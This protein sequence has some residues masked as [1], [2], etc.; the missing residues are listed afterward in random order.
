MHRCG[1]IRM[2]GAGRRSRGLR[3]ALDHEQIEAIYWQ[4]LRGPDQLDR[5]PNGVLRIRAR[6]DHLFTGR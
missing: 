5:N 1:N 6:R 2:Q 3:K 4:R